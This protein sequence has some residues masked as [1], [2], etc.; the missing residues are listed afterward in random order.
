MQLCYNGKPLCPANAAE[1][2]ARWSPVRA[3]SGRVVRFRG[4]IAARGYLEGTSQADLSAKEDALFAALAVGYGDLVLKTDGGADSGT[5]LHSQQV[6]H[7]RGHHRRA[8]TS[9]RPMGAEYV[10]RRTF[11]FTGEAEFVADGADSAVLSFTETISRQGN[12]RP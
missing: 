1:V 11:E 7:R 9:P 3:P 12:G 5:A 2:T 8:R 6:A 10:N 4:Q